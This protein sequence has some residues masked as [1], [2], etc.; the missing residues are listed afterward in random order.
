MFQQKVLF[1]EHSPAPSSGCRCLF[2]FPW[3]SVITTESLRAAQRWSD[4]RWKNIKVQEH[5]LLGQDAALP[6][7]K[8]YQIWNGE[9]ERGQEAAE[10]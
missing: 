3:L 5:L 8:I 9:P 1:A 6:R 4:R 2:V 7:G 10:K